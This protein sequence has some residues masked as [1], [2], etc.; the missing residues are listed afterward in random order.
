M[1]SGAGNSG[2]I[3]YGLYFFVLISFGSCYLQCYKCD[4]TAASTEDCT[5]NMCTGKCATI[6]YSNSQNGGRVDTTELRMCVPNSFS[7]D[8]LCKSKKPVSLS[9]TKCEGSDRDCTCMVTRCSTDLCNGN[10]ASVY[11]TIT[12][13]PMAIVDEDKSGSGVQISRDTQT[14]PSGS[15]SRTTEVSLLLLGIAVIFR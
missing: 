3:A 1:V 7:N 15:G 6:S 8:A 5:S 9:E 12:K 10:F 13:Q 11:Q 4:E 2:L 14:D